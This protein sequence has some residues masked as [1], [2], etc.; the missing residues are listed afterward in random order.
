MLAAVGVQRV[1]VE[2]ARVP[3]Q[4]GGSREVPRAA[5]AHVGHGHGDGAVVDLRLRGKQD[6]HHD[7]GPTGAEPVH[8]EDHV[9]LALFRATGQV[10][11]VASSVRIT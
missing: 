6:L 10:P 2:V 1:R 5:P 4:T 11:G 3:A 9:P 7:V 8:P